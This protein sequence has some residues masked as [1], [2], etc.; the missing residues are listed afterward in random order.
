M[1]TNTQQYL[2]L[3]DEFIPWIRTTS[4]LIDEVIANFDFRKVETAMKALRWSYSGDEDSPSLEAL[5]N[6]ARTLLESVLAEREEDVEHRM[7]GFT[8]S[9]HT[10]GGVS[11]RFTVASSFVCVEADLFLPKISNVR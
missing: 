11:L 7:G 9:W 1:N 8:A 4:E 10:D 6:T 2:S 3:G 5:R